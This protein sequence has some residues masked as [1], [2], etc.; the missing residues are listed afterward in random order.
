MQ[1]DLNN[2]LSGGSLITSLAVSYYFQQKITEIE[3]RL[4]NFEKTQSQLQSS[5]TELN[6]EIRNTS[7]TTKRNADKIN[8]NKRIIEEKM[9]SMSKFLEDEIGGFDSRKQ[10]K[11]D[12]DS[13]DESESEEDVSDSEE[14][15]PKP[16]RSKR[17]KE[18]ASHRR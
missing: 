14:E 3:E 11:H 8:K 7:S 16:K 4:D 1:K 2:Y 15:H 12:S 18:R 13:E 17:V 5:L 10:K 9:Q 6:K